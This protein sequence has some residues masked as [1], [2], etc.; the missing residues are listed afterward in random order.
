MALVKKSRFVT[1]HEK[2]TNAPKIIIF[3][4]QKTSC[5][6]LGCGVCE[7]E[8]SCCHIT[9]VYAKTLDWDWL[10][11]CLCCRKPC[12]SEQCAEIKW[13]LSAHHCK[14]QLNNVS[15]PTSIYTKKLRDLRK[16]RNAQFCL[17]GYWRCSFC[18]IYIF[19]CWASVGVWVLHFT[20]KKRIEL[21][22]QRH[23][24]AFL[25]WKGIVFFL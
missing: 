20:D 18:R 11:K 10:H 2:S 6:L 24:P 5:V 14:K 4:L 16:I 15:A 3:L 19:Q 13:T 23:L 17:E 22:H 25:I 9:L 8:C 1:C 12:S 7:M 21:D